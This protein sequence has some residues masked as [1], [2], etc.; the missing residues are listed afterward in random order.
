MIML[1]IE[2]R[3][4]EAL[5]DEVIFIVSPSPSQS[6]KEFTKETNNLL[7]EVG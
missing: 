1:V 2:K 6:I 4:N 5:R 3:G 7:R